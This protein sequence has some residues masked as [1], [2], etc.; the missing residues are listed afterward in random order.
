[1][2]LPGA[3]PIAAPAVPKDGPGSGYVV[4]D[5]QIRTIIGNEIAARKI[6][7][8]D[9]N[10]LYV[11]FTAP[12]VTLEDSAKMET[13]SVDPPAGWQTGTVSWHD[14]GRDP[15]NGYNLVYALMPSQDGVIN[16]QVRSSGAEIEPVEVTLLPAGR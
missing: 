11:I 5:P 7:A 8:P 6:P 13:S 12:G 16:N 14:Y 2:A 15:V 10:R 3:W 9:A 4:D 1:V